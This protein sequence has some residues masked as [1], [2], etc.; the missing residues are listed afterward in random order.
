MIENILDIAY[1]FGLTEEELTT[2]ALRTFLKAHV[3]QLETEV[4]HLYAQ[5]GVDSLQGTENWLRFDGHAGLSALLGGRGQSGQKSEGVHGGHAVR[6]L[7]SRRK[8]YLCGYPG[9]G[10]NR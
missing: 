5:A 10:D 2:E 1:E 6:R 7:C 9:L 8:N 3:R 4:G